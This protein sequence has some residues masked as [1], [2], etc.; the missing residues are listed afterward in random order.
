M[1]G[2]LVYAWMA[3][4]VVAWLATAYANLDT[5]QYLNHVSGAWIAQAHWAAKGEFYPPLEFDGSFAGTRF[6]PLSIALQTAAQQLFNDPI[7]GPKALHFVYMLAL[8][9]GIG[10]ALRPLGLPRYL[11]LLLTTAP[12][13]TWIGWEAG[14]SIRH[15]ALAAALQVWAVVLVFR[16]GGPTAGSVALAAVLA[17]LAVVAKVSAVWGAGALLIYLLLA[18]PKRVVVLVPVGLATVGGGLALAELLSGGGFSENMSS[19][20][21]PRG[22]VEEAMSF[23]MVADFVKKFVVIVLVEPV[24]VLL[25]LLGVIGAW[26]GRR[27]APH[28][29]VGYL[30]VCLMSAYLMTKDGI[31]ANH[32]ID[33]VAMSC[34]ASGLFFA[35]MHTESGSVKTREGF[36]VC[37]LLGCSLA[38]VAM[39]PELYSSMWRRAGHVAKAFADITGV[40]PSVTVREAALMHF[41]PGERVVAFDPMIPVVLGEDPIVSDSWMLR[42]Y[43]YNHPD[44]EAAFVQRIEAQEFDAFAFPIS[45][46]PELDF[47]PMHFGRASLEAVRKHYELVGDTAYAEFRP[48]KPDAPLE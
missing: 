23:G 18:A 36:V 27:L 39:P 35:T 12:L 34:T 3:V 24:F 4:V 29:S 30:M 41:E 19:C 8:M 1:V 10:Y 42:T 5:P 32:L 45:V 20:L 9:A 22:G 48:I 6:G 2:P 26:R 37:A 25:M 11:C 47:H 14:L 16:R 33:L 31:D 28:V 7:V 17:G 43:F 38:M 21:F 44:A 46:G 40:E 13:V 15:D